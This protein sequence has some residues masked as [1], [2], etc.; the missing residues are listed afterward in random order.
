MDFSVV[1]GNL[2]DQAVDA[3]VVN[4]FSG[5]TE[6]GGGTGTVD[7]ALDGL[8][9]KHSGQ[10]SISLTGLTALHLRRLGR[11]IRIY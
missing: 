5:V 2:T 9:S 7:R 8:I 4:L 10:G 11:W 6:P 3:V 1:T